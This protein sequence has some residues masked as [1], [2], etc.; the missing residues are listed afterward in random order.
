[1]AKKIFLTEAEEMY[2]LYLK[3]GSFKK[4]AIAMNRSPDTVSKYVKIVSARKKK[5][6][7]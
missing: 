6:E 7:E 1:M 4:V 5:E 2:E 3:C